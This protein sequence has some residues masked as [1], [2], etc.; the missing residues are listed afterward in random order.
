MASLKSFYSHSN[1]D[2]SSTSLGA[3]ILFEVV[4][5]M[6]VNK[7]GGYLFSYIKVPSTLITATINVL[8]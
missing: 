8:Q 3:G 6:S 7:G 4:G 2:Q 5:S 1:K